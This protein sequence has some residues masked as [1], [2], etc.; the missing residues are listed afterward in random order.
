MTMGEQPNFSCGVYKILTSQR[1]VDDEQGCPG[2]I[3]IYLSQVTPTGKKQLDSSPCNSHT[4]LCLPL[5][6]ILYLHTYLQQRKCTHTP[7]LRHIRLPGVAVSVVS[8]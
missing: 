8:L 5:T 2:G 1:W 7:A 3:K 4:H 6:R